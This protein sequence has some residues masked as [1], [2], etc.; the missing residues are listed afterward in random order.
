MYLEF[1]VYVDPVIK[2]EKQ[3]SITGGLQYL[4]PLP[5]LDIMV[6]IGGLL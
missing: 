5:I 6:E 2:K 1:F 3:K 4:Q